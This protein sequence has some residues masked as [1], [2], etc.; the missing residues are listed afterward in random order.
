MP[1]NQPP[2]MVDLEQAMTNAMTAAIQPLMEQNVQMAAG[3]Q[4]QRALSSANSEKSNKRQA[5]LLKSIFQNISLPLPG[6]ARLFG[7][8][9]FMDKI[10]QTGK[11]YEA[12][13]AAKL[14]FEQAVT[15]EGKK[16]QEDLWDG[17]TPL[18]KAWYPDEEPKKKRKKLVKTI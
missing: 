17:M 7:L 6:G 9:S 10:G 18:Q 5:G 13:Q 11:K 12:G 2:T 14:K 3:Q 16:A 8:S 15:Q 4:S 1:P